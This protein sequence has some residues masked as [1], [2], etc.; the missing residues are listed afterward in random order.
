MNAQE[1]KQ[2]ADRVSTQ[3]TDSQFDEIM[4]LIKKEAASGRHETTYYGEVKPAVTEKLRMLGYGIYASTH[5]NETD[6][7]IKWS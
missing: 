6:T 5:R 7:Q 3:G 1:A 2:L 4:K